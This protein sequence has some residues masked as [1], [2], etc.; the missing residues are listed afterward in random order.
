[1]P[2]CLLIF[3]RPETTKRVFEI[4]RRIRPTRL[5][6]VADGPRRGNQEEAVLCK[7]ARD[8]VSNVDWECELL[9][10][11]AS[12]NM[13]LRARV[14]SGLTWVFEQVEKAIILEDD[15]LPDPSFFKFCDILLD[16]YSDDEC[17]MMVSGDN[18]HGFQPKDADYYF[19][20]YALIWGWATW[21][22]AW[23]KY[24][25]AMSDWHTKRDSGW[26]EQIFS[27]MPA[28]EYWK[29]KFED[30]HKRFNS[31]AGAWVYACFKHNGL[32][33]VPGCNLVSNIGFGR[34]ATHTIG[35]ADARHAVE[36]RSMS[37]PLCHPSRISTDSDADRFI[38]RRIFSGNKIPVSQDAAELSDVLSAWKAGNPW[39]ALRKLKNVE[40]RLRGSVFLSTAKAALLG[41]LGLWNQA[42]ELI[43]KI[44][45]DKFDQA[46]KKSPPVACDQKDGQRDAFIFEKKKPDQNEHRKFMR[47]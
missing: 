33:A 30:I 2:V 12:E 25:D 19:T 18:A 24:D 20:R 23:E 37:F 13:G 14:S 16:R 15:C 5:L 31:W 22:R 11:F 44:P 7:S 46:S 42:S 9:T 10:N 26:V 40:T 41:S 29:S 34:E 35:M 28:V 17:V 43:A 36:T 4:I 3:R 1:M 39:A 8:I 6:V 21:R 45:L 27:D 38:E 32:C 47:G